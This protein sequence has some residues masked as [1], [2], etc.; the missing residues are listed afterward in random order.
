M[1]EYTSAA[2]GEVY[3]D[4]HFILPADAFRD[5][6]MLDW[7]VSTKGSD[8]STYDDFNDLM[9]SRFEEKV[10]GGGLTG[11]MAIEA[12]QTGLA[13]YNTN[14]TFDADI[15]KDAPVTE[16]NLLAL[17]ELYGRENLE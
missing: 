14:E 5:K 17:Q 3:S 16:Q 10:A 11:I 1:K 8:E 12:R 6:P 15:D 13:Q 7:I 4:G 2:S 9:A